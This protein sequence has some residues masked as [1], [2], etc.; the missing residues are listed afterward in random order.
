MHL[1]QLENAKFAVLIDEAHSSQNGQF[2]GK[3]KAALK[4]AAAEKKKA[5]DTSDITDEELINAYFS[6]EQANRVMPENV[7]FFAFTATP[8]AETKTLFGRD[9]GLRKAIFLM[10]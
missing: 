3:M 2:A 7:S 8:K 1:K 10:Y 5:K 9:S 6:E 4:L